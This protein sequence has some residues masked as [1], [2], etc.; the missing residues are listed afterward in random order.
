MIGKII[1]SAKRS[2]MAQMA[3]CCL[4]PVLLIIGLQFLGFSG[5]WVFALAIAV[6]IGSHIAMGALSAEK[7]G[8]SCH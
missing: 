1:E 7:E 8:K 4:L 3:I 5:P 2:H 6:C